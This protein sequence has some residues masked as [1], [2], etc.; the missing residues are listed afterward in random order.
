VVNREQPRLFWHQSKPANAKFDLT[1]LR[2][3]KGKPRVQIT[4]DC[5]QGGRS[6]FRLAKWSDSKSQWPVLPGLVRN[7]GWFVPP[8]QSIPGTG[9]RMTKK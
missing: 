6:P 4:V 1:L 3:K 5:S 8:G 7:A 2:E 9:A